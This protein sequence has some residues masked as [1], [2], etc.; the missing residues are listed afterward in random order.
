MQV[1]WSAQLPLCRAASTHP[2]THLPTHSHTPCVHLRAKRT[3]ERGGG[4]GGKAAAAQQQE[5]QQQQQQQ[6]QQPYDEDYGVHAQEVTGGQ[7]E[8][9]GEAKGQKMCVRKSRRQC[10]EAWWL[11]EAVE[12]SHTQKKQNKRSGYLSSSSACAALW[13]S[14]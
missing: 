7:E 6:Q 3:A 1:R 8:E 9:K 10:T 14:T 2:P 13:V 5:Q 12:R 11:C 4:G